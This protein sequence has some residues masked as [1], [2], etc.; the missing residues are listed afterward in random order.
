[1]IIYSVGGYMIYRYHFMKMTLIIIQ[2][3]TGFS[4]EVTGI[5]SN[6]ARE[7]RNRSPTHKSKQ[8]NLAGKNTSNWSDRN[9]DLNSGEVENK[10]ANM[11]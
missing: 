5:L 3:L 6:F 9:G 11:G 8:L 10:T 7:C 1:M 2:N 4:C